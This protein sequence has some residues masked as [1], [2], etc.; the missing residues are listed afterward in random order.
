M[1]SWYEAAANRLDSQQMGPEYYA[2]GLAGE[3]GEAVEH[4]KKAIRRQHRTPLDTRAF[5]LE[6]GDVLW[7]LTRLANLSGYTLTQVMEMNV[8]KLEARQALRPKRM[9]QAGEVEAEHVQ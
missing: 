6:L 1:T 5:A 9:V 4:I 7:Y 8:A 3:C 2:L